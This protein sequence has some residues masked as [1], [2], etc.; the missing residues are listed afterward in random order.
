MNV[1]QVTCIGQVSKDL[2]NCIL[3]VKFHILFQFMPASI[4][5]ASFTDGLSISFALIAC[6]SKAICVLGITRVVHCLLFV[7]FFKCV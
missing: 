3:Y 5:D 1:L 4:L 2:I 7:Y 6:V